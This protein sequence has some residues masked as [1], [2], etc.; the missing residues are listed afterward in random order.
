LL[1]PEAAGCLARRF[2][3]VRGLVMRLALTSRTGSPPRVRGKVAHPKDFRAFA[4]IAQ[5]VS[6]GRLIL[7]I[8]ASTARCVAAVGIGIERTIEPRSRGLRKRRT[9]SVASAT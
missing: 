1:Q 4:V 2:P 6:N 8:P 7:G 9:L 3:F 5:A